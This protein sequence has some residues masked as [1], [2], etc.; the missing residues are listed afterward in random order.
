VPALAVLVSLARGGSAPLPPATLWIPPNAVAVLEL[1][2][3]AAFLDLALAPEFL[4]SISSL[5]GYEKLSAQP[6]FK[7]LL[8]LVRYLE[9]NLDLDWRPAVRKLLA[10]SV[11]LAVMPGDASLVVVDAEDGAILEKL[12]SAILGLVRLDAA[13][14]I[15]PARA[16]FR[17]Y[18]GIKTWTFEGGGT[19]AVIKN[20]LLLASKPEVLE[21]VLDLRLEPKPDTLASLPAYRA[22]QKAV[23][24]DAAGTLF[25]NLA[26]LKRNP[27]LAQAIAKNRNP[28][29]S[30]LFAGMTDALRNSR[31]LALGLHVKE[32][33]LALEATVDARAVDAKDPA[34]FGRP[35]RQGEGA[36]PNPTIP[37]RIAAFSLYRDLYRF[38]AAKDALFPERTS[39]LIFFENM[40]GIFFSGRD[41]TEEVLAETKP[42]LRVVVAEPVYDP[43]IGTPRVKIPAFAAILRLKNPEAFAVVVEEAW[44]KALG[45]VNFTRGQQG[46]PGLIIDRLVQGE[47]KFTV[48]GFSTAGVE[49]RKNLEDRFNFRPSI[50]VQGDALIL[51]STDSLARDLI[52]ALKAEAESPPAPMERIDTF[53]EIDGRG[54]ASALAA[55]H[56][57]LV[58]QNMIGKGNTRKQA[59]L[60]IDVL[61]ALVRH[62]KQTTFRL[63]TRDGRPFAHL[64]IQLCIP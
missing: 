13:I 49:D 62:V 3:P 35:S 26:L 57:A 8:G 2:K 52:D 33:T 51:S 17:A 37:G 5:E 20:R 12:H 63:G 45:L 48:A 53:L 34:A 14:N 41:L 43:D 47:T 39:E 10:G 55:N 1:R 56:E 36:L 9:N 15:R 32:K 11:T 24:P 50:A 29:A 64:A 19:Y 58:R 54:V 16:S 25:L 30:F 38:Y 46:Q 40:M 27:A 21:A 61:T 18:R 23:G 4:G 42:G 59:E 44:Q 60:I 31:W 6:G 28:I 22:A 7:K